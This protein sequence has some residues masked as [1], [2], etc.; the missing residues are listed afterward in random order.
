M[1]DLVSTIRRVAREFQNSL[2][3]AFFEGSEYKKLLRAC[4]SFLMSGGKSEQNLV[5]MELDFVGS[6]VMC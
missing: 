3:F 5:L 6:I 1:I 2:F 4:K